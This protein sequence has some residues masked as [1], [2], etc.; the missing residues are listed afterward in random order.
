M[1][2]LFTLFLL[3][4]GD[5][6]FNCRFDKVENELEKQS[7]CGARPVRV[8]LPLPPDG[9]RL[10]FKKPDNPSLKGYFHRRRNGRGKVKSF[11]NLINLY[12]VDLYLCKND[13][14]KKKTLL[15]RLV[16]KNGETENLQCS[17]SNK[18]NKK[19]NPIQKVVK[20]KKETKSA[21][22]VKNQDT[23][24][25]AGNK[26]D[27]SE[28]SLVKGVISVPR[29]V[30]AKNDP[31]ARF[32]ALAGLIF[33]FLIMIILIII[34]LRLRSRLLKFAKRLDELENPQVVKL[35]KKTKV[36]VKT[37]KSTNDNSASLKSPEEKAPISE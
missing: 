37:A 23:H 11:Y 9:K 25:N 19:L 15:F 1:T 28:E 32:L 21:T 3:I 4:P 8:R 22:R 35:K 24:E 36:D 30:P 5:F 20:S 10:E 31:F 18:D 6:D 17:L 13:F 7:V 14:Q 26:Q 2:A 12:S 33:S 34:N 16:K 29:F 27:K